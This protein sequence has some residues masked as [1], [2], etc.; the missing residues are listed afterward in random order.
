MLAEIEAVE[1]KELHHISF[2]KNFPVCHYSLFSGFLAFNEYSR[3]FQKSQRQHQV[4][5]QAQ[6]SQQHQ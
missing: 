4:R 2:N 1:K 3:P 5:N 6:L